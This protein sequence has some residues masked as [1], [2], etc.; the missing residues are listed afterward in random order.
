MSQYSGFVPIYEQNSEFRS[1]HFEINTGFESI[2]SDLKV[3]E[4][5]ELLV[6]GWWDE[7]DNFSFTE[8]ISSIVDSGSKFCEIVVSTNSVVETVVAGLDNDKGEGVL[9]FAHSEQL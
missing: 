3:V 8:N 7:V 5:V 1:S 2:A 4:T 6:S 9:G